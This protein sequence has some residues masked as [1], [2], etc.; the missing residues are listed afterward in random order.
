G[1]PHLLAGLLV[2]LVA[3]PGGVPLVVED[4][5]VRDVDG[6][7][8]GHDAAGLGP[9]PAGLDL[10]VL[11]D[12]VHTLDQH[13]VELGV[14]RDD[15][16]PRAAVLTGDHLDHVVLPDLHAHST[17]GASEMIFMNRLS[18]SSRPTGPKM[19]VPRG[20]PPSRRIT[21]AFSSKRMYDPSGRR[22]S[23]AVRTTTARTGSPFFTPAPGIAS[24]TVATI[25]S[26]MPAY[27]RPEPPSTRMQRISRAP[28]LSATRSRDSC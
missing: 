5:H 17:S 6:G 3:D 14:D 4:H 26:P 8:L 1:D 10:G 27:R 22:R 21:A 11:A 25:W 7:L 9:P 16:A 12:P 18:R 23:L 2:D 13:P 28:V 19:R 24:L 20:S 15:L